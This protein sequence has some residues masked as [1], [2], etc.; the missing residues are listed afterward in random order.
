MNIHIIH[1]TSICMKIELTCSMQS[2]ENW[3]S[4]RTRYGKFSM[5]SFAYPQQQSHEGEP[6]RGVEAEREEHEEENDGPE[7]AA[8]HAGDGLGVHHEHQPRPFVHHI[9]HLLVGSLGHVAQHRKDDEARHE[10]CAA[11]DA[12]G[13]K[14][15]PGRSLGKE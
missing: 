11:I 14:G 15:I 6:H 10:G 4:F 7:A 8:R 13:H 2:L 5:H 9:L 1:V 12:G 3:I